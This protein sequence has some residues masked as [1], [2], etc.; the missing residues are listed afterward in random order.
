MNRALSYHEIF[1]EGSLVLD[2]ALLCA[3]SFPQ[4][5]HNFVAYWKFHA[6]DYWHVRPIVQSAL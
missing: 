6:G 3:Q 5:L 4:R 1:E 2:W